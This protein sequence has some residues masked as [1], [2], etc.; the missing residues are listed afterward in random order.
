MTKQEFRQLLIKNGYTNI[1]YNGHL[2]CF[3]ADKDKTNISFNYPFSL[4]NISYFTC[5]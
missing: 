4:D 1:R 5:D 2:K 3:Y